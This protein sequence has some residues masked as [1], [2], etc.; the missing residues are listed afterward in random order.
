VA[1]SVGALAGAALVGIALGI[2]ALLL[3]LR[4]PLA[5]L[6]GEEEWLAKAKGT[7][8]PTAPP[9]AT[10]IR[11]ALACAKGQALGFVLFVALVCIAIVARGG[12]SPRAAC[13]LLFCSCLLSLGLADWRTRLLP[14]A[15]TQPM[16][17]LGLILQ[18]HPL[19]R[20]IG[21]ENA[22]LGATLGYL[23]PWVAGVA[24]LL[25]GREDPVGGGDL[26]LT[27]LLGAWLGPVAALSSLF[28]A[29]LGVVLLYGALLLLG[30]RQADEPLPFGPW[31]AAAGVGLVLVKA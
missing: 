17:W 12:W 31:L 3:A 11:D 6:D 26:K 4:L 16:I 1:L 22:V 9:F 27:A 20:T 25:M 8:A 14:D 19:T 13:L 21:I 23:L 29:S 30:K 2:A 18:L 24:K 10:R 5:I 7:P 28:A 15:M